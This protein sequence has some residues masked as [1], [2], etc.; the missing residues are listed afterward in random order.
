MKSSWPKISRSVS[1]K[2]P[3]RE[4]NLSRPRSL[5]AM[6]MNGLW[7][8]IEKTQPWN[9]SVTTNSALAKDDSHSSI[10]GSSVTSS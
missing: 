10:E 1:P 4:V 7:Y 2:V 9:E 3:S 5:F 8:M 6:A